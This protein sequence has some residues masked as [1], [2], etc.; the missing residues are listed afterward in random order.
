MDS[1]RNLST[2]LP[3]SSR[4]RLDQPEL[5][6]DFKAAALSV[7]NLYKSAVSVQ[8]KARAIGYQDA[9]D[10][11]LGFLDKEEMGLMDGEGWRVRRWATER[12]DEGGVEREGE[13]SE[14]EAEPETAKDEAPL[15]AAGTRSS[16]PE[17]QRKAVVPREG[18]EDSGIIVSEPPRLSQQQQRQ[19][20]RSPTPT[21][22]QHTAQQQQQHTVPTA[23]TFTFRSSHTYPNPNLNVDINNHDRER[24]RGTSM[25]VDT[26]SQPHMSSSTPPSSS[27]TTLRHYPHPRPSRNH[28]HT[29]HNRQR[30]RGTNE[31]GSR[32][33]SGTISLNLSA[34]SGKRKMPYPD[35]FDISGVNFDGNDGRR[36][37]SGNGRGTGG[38]GGKRGR[39][40]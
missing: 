38:G 14:G 13:G 5:L 21:P 2:S 26:T 18:S 10:D 15:P 37:G 23:E 22:P 8:A 40:V 31:N 28:R 34:N 19:S 20:T 17:A 9:L 27:D 33:A 1:M 25:E 3:S 4:R 35:F 36:D 12:L 6:M 39:H 30:E 16:S 7:T 32:A 11:L 29:N 24:E